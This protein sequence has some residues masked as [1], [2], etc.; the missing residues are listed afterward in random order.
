[1]ESRNRRSFV[2]DGHCSIHDI[3]NITARHET[4]VKFLR[5]HSL[6]KTQVDCDVPAF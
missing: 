4:A 6:L 5:D 3:Y 2:E 1:M